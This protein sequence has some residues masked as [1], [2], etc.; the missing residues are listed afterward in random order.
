MK[1][2]IQFIVISLLATTVLRQGGLLH[3]VQQDLPQAQVAH[4][5]VQVAQVVRLLAQATQ[6]THLVRSQVKATLSSDAY[7]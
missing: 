6:A 7:C 2:Q 1:V 5:Q 3:Q 4:L